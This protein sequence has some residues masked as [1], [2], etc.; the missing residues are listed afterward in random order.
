M[1]RLADEHP[2]Q[3]HD[4]ECENGE[5]DD[6][7]ADHAAFELQSVV[8]ALFLELRL[9]GEE[10]HPV[11]VEREV[12]ARRVPDVPLEPFGRF[13]VRDEW[14]DVRRVDADKES[15][16]GDAAAFL[17][18]LSEIGGAETAD[19]LVDDRLC[20]CIAEVDVA[21]R[22]AD[23]VDGRRDCSPHWI[24]VIVLVDR[25][26]VRDRRRLDPALMGCVL[27]AD[28]LILL[29]LGHAVAHRCAALF[30]E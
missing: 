23:A 25:D 15:R 26:D 17:K 16:H 18:P 29:V 20:G 8:A 4:E 1:T 21:A 12:V 9:R 6:D 10:H 24:G 11:A 14:R 27:S 5:D 13:G 19:R 30:A 7:L 28:E 2:I 3:D 22:V